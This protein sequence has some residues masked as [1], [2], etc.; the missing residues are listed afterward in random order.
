KNTAIAMGANSN[1]QKCVAGELDGR[2]PTLIII[3]L[4]FVKKHS[5]PTTN[6]VST[7]QKQPHFLC[8]FDYLLN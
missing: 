3:V 1:F 5:P 4:Y 6:W 7:K 2:S 8:G